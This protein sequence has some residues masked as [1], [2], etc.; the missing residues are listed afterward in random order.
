MPQ[1]LESSKA[2]TSLPAWERA[3]GAVVGLK[4]DTPPR[5]VFANLEALSLNGSVRVRLGFVVPQRGAPA[6]AGAEAIPPG[7]H[8]KLRE[9]QATWVSSA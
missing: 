1:M 5:S 6:G 7:S 8:L 2:R 3:Q 9:L 4:P